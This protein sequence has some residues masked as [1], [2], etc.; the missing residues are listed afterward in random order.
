MFVTGV[1][2]S[3]QWSEKGYFYAIQIAQFGLGHYCRNLVE[4][5]A[6]FIFYEDGESGIQV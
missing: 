5:P 1:P 6:K 4:K 3:I 2:L